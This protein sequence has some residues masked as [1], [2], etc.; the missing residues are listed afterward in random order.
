MTAAVPAKIVVMG[1]S[2]AGKSTVG[3]AIAALLGAR[4]V[5]GDDLHTPAAVEQMRAG[6]PLDDSDR[7]PWLD[8]I[9]A[10]LA[11]GAGAGVVV[12]CSALKRAY[13]DRIRAAAGEGLVFVHLSGARELI[14][15]RQAARP[16]HYMPAEL[17]KSQFETLEEPVGEA[18]VVTFDVRQEPETI[19]E[20]AVKAIAGRAGG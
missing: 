14:A 5:D 10:V 9:G 13:R 11:G 8:R 20:R 2:G 3:R 15:D 17:M 4:F 18:D 1:V 12:A 19:A 16:E 7:W 6:I